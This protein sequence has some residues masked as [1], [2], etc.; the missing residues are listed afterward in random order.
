MCDSGFESM[1]QSHKRALEEMRAAHKEEIE[2][3]Q[4]EKETV[5]EEE[6]Q[7]THAGRWRHL[8]DTLCSQGLS[9]DFHNRVFKLGFQ[10]FRVSKIPGRKSKNHYT[11]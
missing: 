9:Q 1:Q 7:A 11:D 3:L 5:L 6:T 8:A 10:E 4:Q 2:R